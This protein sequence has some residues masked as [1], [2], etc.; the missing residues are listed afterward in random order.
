MSDHSAY[1]V[2][3][4]Q[5]GATDQEIRQAFIQLVKKYDPEIHT[6]RF[7]LIQDAYNKLKEPK[8]RAHEDL[9][10]YN[11]I[12]GE[13]LFA[14]D[15]KPGEDSKGPDEREIEKARDKF[16]SMAGDPRERK[17]FIQLLMQRSYVHAKRK[18]WTEA[19][20]E[21]EEVYSID[22]SH[23]R[24]R[25]NLMYGCIMLGTTYALHS[26]DEDAIELWER[27]LELNPDNVELIHNLALA[28]EKGGKHEDSAR[29]WA[30]VINRWRQRLNKD[31]D[32]EYMREV[33]VEAHRHHGSARHSG[34]RPKLSRHSRITPVPKSS[35]RATETPSPREEQTTPEPSASD[36][37]VV[38]RERYRQVLELKPDD[39]DARFQL[40]QSLVDD[41]KYAE[42][43][44]QLGELLA[45]HPKSV[46]VINVLGWALLHNGQVDKAFDEWNKS[47]KLDPKNAVTRE[48]IVRA[49]LTLGK[50]YRQKG[51]F[52][53]ALVHL[54]KLQRYMPKSAEVMME[55]GAT[56]D[57]KGDLRSAM[58]A[59]EQVLQIDP[60]NKLARKAI[61]D[62][63]MKR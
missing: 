54:K 25:N 46:E 47:L 26:L 21:W 5:K 60:K 48:N 53:P 15:E 41:R 37:K 33:L 43:I 20:R 34:E 40:A 23:V 61:N 57:M 32:D 52:T 36:S 39:F 44:E 8:K 31:Q 6:D 4:I 13:F 18:M 42:A 63:R 29:Y 59:Y 27:S 24:A 11:V 10:T 16:R 51:M 22:P 62:I 2:L 30:E 35:K 17:N 58:Q 45:K 3:G 14:D 1:A 49:H 50:Q 56:Y 55:I 19:I 38:M 12:K 28:C 9:H 7:L